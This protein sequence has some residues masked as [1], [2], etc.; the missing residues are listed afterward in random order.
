[1]NSVIYQAKNGAIELRGD[2][3]DETIWATQAQIVDL[4]VLINLLFLDISIIF[5]K[6]VKLIKKAIC[7][8]C[9]LQIRMVALVIQM[10]R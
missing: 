5:L 10:L 1:M 9:I 3:K 4:F 2:F 7:K 8:K 6:T